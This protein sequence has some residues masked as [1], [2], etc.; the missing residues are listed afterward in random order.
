[1]KNI[2]KSSIWVEKYRPQSFDD[3]IVPSGVRK[4]LKQIKE[5]GETPNL[6]FSGI[7]G[8]GKTATA[9]AITNE[10]GATMMHM[11]CSFNTSINDIRF[12]VTRFAT[13][14]SIENF[15]GKK[16]AILDECDRLSTEAMDSLKGLIEEVHNN[17]RFIFITNRYQK[18]IGP[19]NSRTQHFPFGATEAEKEDLVVQYFKRCQFILDNEGIE[20]DMQTLARFITELF[21][22]FRK[23]LNELQKFSKSN[24]EINEGIF[25][26][27]DDKLINGLVDVMKTRKF[28]DMRK[29]V[30]ELDPQTFY[31]TMYGNMDE[32]LQDKIKPD[33]VEI[34]G[35]WAAKDGTTIDRE[36]NMAACCTILMKTCNGNWVGQDKKK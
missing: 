36:V 7:H 9:K 12:E 6:L 28:N 20:Y 30:S 31:S 18:I 8:T 5:D 4:F 10:L 15:G 27:Q 1:M 21:P 33:V 25:N 17:C 22:D 14:N 29:I 2:G 3:L 32:Y 35:E 13:T 34:L 26:Y 24:G 16:I 11:N 23:I 19:L